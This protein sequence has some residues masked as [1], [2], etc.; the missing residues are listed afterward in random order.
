MKRNDKR[1]TGFTLIEMAMVVLVLGLLSVGAI[2]Y[3]ELYSKKEVEKKSQKLFNDVAFQ[4]EEFRLD[5]GRYPCPANLFAPR[6]TAAY[7]VE[8][9]TS[10]P[11]LG[12]GCNNNYCV[13]PGVAFPGDTA[14][15]IAALIAAATESSSAT[16]TVASTEAAAVAGAI[17]AMTGTP[18]PA[19]IGMVTARITA[20]V[21]GA[22]TASDVVTTLAAVTI[23]NNRVR[24]GVIPFKTLALQEDH[25][26]DEHGSR[27]FYAVTETL[28][29]ATT[30]SDQGGRINIVDGNNTSVVAP[31]DNGIAGGARTLIF[32][33]GPNRN[34]AIGLEGATG[35]A[36]F[37][38]FCNLAA[39]D[40]ANCDFLLPGGA[41]APATVLA[42][43]PLPASAFV[44]T[45]L[46]KGN[47]PLLNDQ[48]D[49][50]IYTVNAYKSQ[51]L[52]WRHGEPVDPVTGVATGE[53]AQDLI[54]MNRKVLIGDRA[55]LPEAELHIAGTS[56]DF[57]ADGSVLAVDFCRAGD[58][59]DV[60]CFEVSEFEKTG[61]DAGEYITGFG[62]FP[63][64]ETE[65]A[66][67]GKH[68]KTG[69]IY[70]GC[71]SNVQ[72]LVGKD[73]DGAP[74]C[75]NIED[76]ILGT[77]AGT[78]GGTTGGTTQLYSGAGKA[79]SRPISTG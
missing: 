54:A 65:A 11:F 34:G 4:L 38:N 53:R 15:A 9:C 5:T 44:N 12:A 75:A 78:I 68:V 48:D 57:F 45:L 79:S 43:S 14:V 49:R 66:G 52:G 70:F 17:A 36:G 19:E 37:N 77:F 3:Y 58:P 10:T 73:A 46:A 13:Q 55:A 25:S 29:N 6:N 61:L 60:N 8:N 2:Q 59:D 31:S 32:S 23:R 22:T 67:F 39:A 47:N 27:L 56:G 62:N 51:D 21:A 64:H 20:A 16:A 74:I 35:L 7:G 72:T 42:G 76:V 41:V 30:Y 18:T 63:A 24:I 69:G 50:L 71:P 26:L 1:N 33:V 28:M 40:A